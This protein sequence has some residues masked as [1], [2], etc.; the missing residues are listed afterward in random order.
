MQFGFANRMKKVSKSAFIL[1][2]CCTVATDIWAQLPSTKIYDPTL[3]E[4]SKKK[5]AE[6]GASVMPAY[7]KLLRDAEK[8]LTITY[9]S[10]VEK[11]LPS[12]SG[13]MHDYVSLSPYWWPN[14]STASGLPYVRRDGHR[15]PETD[16][17]DRDALDK[18]FKGMEM[19][20]LA[21]YFSGEDKYAQKATQ[22][23]KMWMV[24]KSARMNPNLNYAQFVPGVNDEM[25]RGYGIIDTYSMVYLTDYIRILETSGALDAKDMAS[26]RNWFAQ[27]SDW[28]LNSPNGQDEASAENNHGLAYDVQLATTL[29]FAGDTTRAKELLANFHVKRVYPQ[30]EADGSQPFELVRTMA[31]H[32]SLF[33]L[34]HMLDMC[35]LARSFNMDLYTKSDGNGRSI[36]AALQFLLPFANQPQDMWPYQQ[37]RDW[38]KTQVNLAW[39]IQR[40]ASLSKKNTN[41][42]I[43]LMDMNLSIEHVYNLL[44]S[45]E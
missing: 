41:G 10:V 3:L 17:Y 22:L 12:P 34:W 37:I 30:V 42:Q 1:M 45:F 8:A 33:N 31:M 35:E 43:R 44:Y 21:Y 24:D 25:G 20:S 38:D 7:R 36:D 19:L 2:L 16:K 27:F 26:V 39:T 18:F 13:D 6:G 32:Y 29:V 23:L 28:L 4:S 9:P 40:C 5:I 11:E 15:N 14:P